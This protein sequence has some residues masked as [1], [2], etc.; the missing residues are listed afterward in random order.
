MRPRALSARST[1]LFVPQ[2]PHGVQERR[3]IGRV[4]AGQHAHQG[5][6]GQSQKHQPAGDCEKSA[7]H[8]HLL[9]TQNPENES[10][11]PQCLQPGNYGACHRNKAPSMQGRTGNYLMK[12]TLTNTLNIQQTTLI[13]ADLAQPSR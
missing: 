13:T 2:S 5:G 4:Q 9:R 6:E 12:I 11:E 1:R 3:A 8:S 10:V 7:S